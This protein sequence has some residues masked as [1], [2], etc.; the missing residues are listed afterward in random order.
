[1]THTVQQR[2]RRGERAALLL[3]GSALLAAVVLGVRAPEAVPGAWRLGVFACLQPALG[4]VIFVLI[5]RLT[6]GQWMDGLA[7]FLG[8]GA[9]L[10]PWVWLLAL[11][12]LAWPSAPVR[13]PVAASGDARISP[14][15]PAVVARRAD[16]SATAVGPLVREPAREPTARPW[17]FRRSWVAARALG[18]TVFFFLLAAGVARV[19]RGAEP[20][21]LRWFGPAGLIGLVFLLHLLAIDWIARLEPGW[22]STGFPLVWI[23]AQALGGLAAATAAALWLG[24]EPAQ[25]GSAGRVL[26]FDLGNLLLAAAMTWTYVAFAQWLIIWSG[27]LPAETSWYRH[28][29]YGVWRW[30]LVA[31]AVVEF[32]APV[33]LLLSRG[34]KRRRGA[35]AVTAALLL[36]GQL[37]YTVWLIAPALGTQGAAAG[38][39]EACATGGAVGLFLNRYLAGAR[40]AAAA[41]AA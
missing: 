32:A 24:A 2:L 14:E 26:G 6:G 16:V 9:R 29:T 11:P 30:L 39:L 4:S 3:G 35:L 22:Y 17:Y 23:V 28:R 18:Y 38:W 12:L 13:V 1:M 31:L 20:A 33:V 34:V 37:G 5:H 27:N 41:C 21:A 10:L 40:R 36:A 7:P 25:R 15:R 8:A 19:L